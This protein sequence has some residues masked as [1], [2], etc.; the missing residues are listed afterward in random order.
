MSYFKSPPQLTNGDAEEFTAVLSTSSL[1]LKLHVITV[2][3]GNAILDGL[4]LG[5]DHLSEAT[6]VIW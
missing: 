6:K 5:H 3:V 1:V 4:E 2:Q